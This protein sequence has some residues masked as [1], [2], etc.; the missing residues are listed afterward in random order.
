VRVVQAI[1][2]TNKL[3]VPTAYYT[4]KNIEFNGSPDVEGV[5]FFAGGNIDLKNVTINRTTP[6]L[7]NDWDTTNPAN[8]APTSN[9]NTVPRRTGPNATDTKLTSTGFA[10]EGIICK[11]NCSGPSD[12][13]AD[14]RYDYDSTT[15][16]KG[17]LKRFVRKSN[18]DISNNAVNASGTISYPFNPNAKFDLTSLENIAR[19]QGNY[20]EGDVN[21]VSTATGGAKYPSPSSDQTVFYVRANG[22]T[23]DYR[24]DYNPQAKGLIVVEGGNFDIQNSSSG[25]DG[26]VIVTGTAAGSA[27]DCNSTS[28]TG[29][30]KNSGNKTVRGFVIADN[31]MTIGGTVDPF[32]VVG[33]YTQRPGFYSM[34][35]WSWRECYSTNCT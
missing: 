13:I 31:T 29:C 17:S 4:P 6:A 16:L 25:F 15:A 28:A 10:A 14:G 7:Y 3:D 11:N 12:S 27:L 30:Y 21:I 5:S 8:F 22:A 32:S 35:L 33:E 19:G 2:H 23:T 9:L 34:K 26:V 24:A 1:V 20:Y 18:A